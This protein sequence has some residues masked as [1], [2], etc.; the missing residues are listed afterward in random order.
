MG[1]GLTIS[2]SIIEWHGGALRM[3]DNKRSGAIFA[4]DLP[5]GGPR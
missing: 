3:A 1:M 5:T 2:R 4:F